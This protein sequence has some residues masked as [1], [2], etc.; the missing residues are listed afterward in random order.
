MVNYELYRR[1]A[2]AFKSNSVSHNLPDC[3]KYI[4]MLLD[5]TIKPWFPLTEHLIY[6]IVDTAI[7]NPTKKMNNINLTLLD[8]A[9]KFEK[10]LRGALENDN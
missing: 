1:I 4:H 8:R 6:S 10:S 3:R 2:E 7:L 9:N 5:P